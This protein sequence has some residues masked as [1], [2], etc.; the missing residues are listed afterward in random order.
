MPV[1]RIAAK[2]HDPR[3]SPANTFEARN[4]VIISPTPK[5]TLPVLSIAARR[6]PPMSLNREL[7]VV[8][9]KPPPK[10]NRNQSAAIRG[11]LP[12]APGKNHRAA[13]IE[14]SPATIAAFGPRMSISGPAESAASAR[15][16]A[17]VSASVPFCSPVKPSAGSKEPSMEEITPYTRI[18]STTAPRSQ[19]REGNIQSYQ[20]G[21]PCYS[22]GLE[23]LFR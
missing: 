2:K 9:I 14:V 12:A 18:D 21:T 6:T 13:A 3:T 1:T 16:T 11:N 15:P 23:T 19:T 22:D 20:L 17:C 10:P 7:D 4:G 8:P 5:N